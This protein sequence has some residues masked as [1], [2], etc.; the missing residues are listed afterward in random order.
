MGLRVGVTNHNTITDVAHRAL[1]PTEG[2]DSP[3]PSPGSPASY[4]QLLGVN[5]LQIQSAGNP[6]RTRR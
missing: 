4:R 1:T 6:H 2:P 5:R 3:E